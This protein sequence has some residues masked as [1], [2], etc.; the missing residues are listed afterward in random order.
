M[1]TKLGKK[2]EILPRITTFVPKFRQFK[3]ISRP[4]VIQGKL[5]RGKS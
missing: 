1:A 2:P 3:T 4:Y 5:K